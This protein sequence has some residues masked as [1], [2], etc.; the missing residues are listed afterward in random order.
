MI[1]STQ[2]NSSLARTTTN[3]N[4]TPEILNS[5]EGYSGLLMEKIVAFCKREDARNG[6]NADDQARKQKE[7]AQTATDKHKSQQDIL[8]FCDLLFFQR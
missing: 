7:A 1:T 6:I 5:T 8:V 3:L 4:V 2:L